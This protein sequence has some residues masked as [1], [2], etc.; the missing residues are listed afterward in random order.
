[1]R[2]LK[3]FFTVSDDK[4]FVLC[5]ESEESNLFS[6]EDEPPIFIIPKNE[7]PSCFPLP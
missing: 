2:Y 6:P 1:M 7:N 5:L 3:E 4:L